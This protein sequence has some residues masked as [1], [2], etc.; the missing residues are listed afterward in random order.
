MI[1]GK[2]RGYL[3]IV[4][5]GLALKM[6]EKKEIISTYRLPLPVKTTTLTLGSKERRGK[7][8]DNSAAMVSVNA[9]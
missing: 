2:E 1:Y 6:E 7:R 4:P 5:N 3:R 8:D 9:F